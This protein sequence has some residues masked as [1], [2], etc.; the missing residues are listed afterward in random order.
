MREKFKAFWKIFV[1]IVLVFLI[2]VG[3]M[4]AF[5][6]LPI[7]G[8]YM[9]LSVMSGSMAPTVSTGSVV[10]VKPI[11]LLQ[12]RVG[13]IITFKSP[14]DRA[15]KDNITHRIYKI[16]EKDGTRFFVTK[17]DANDT[18]DVDLVK[19]DKLAGKAYFSIPLLGYLF[20][21]I[22]TLPGLVLLIIVPATIII[23]EEV[24]KLKSEAKKIVEKRRAERK[25]KNSKNAL[26]AK[27]TAK[28][29][30]ASLMKKRK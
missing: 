12:Y 14:D 28:E 9:I 5:S 7:R 23:Y 8:N 24:R 2:I 11:E 17:G 6:M 20:G 27:K 15:I 18:P 10:V 19:P 3:L 29:I 21:Y 26:L 4:T 25:S 1:N 30:P 13:D 16:E 22:K